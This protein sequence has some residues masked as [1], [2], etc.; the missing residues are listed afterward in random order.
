MGYAIVH[1]MLKRSVKNKTGHGYYVRTYY[2]VKELFWSYVA[3]QH[4]ELALFSH[5]QQ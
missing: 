5:C 4:R 3:C 1:G 2:T